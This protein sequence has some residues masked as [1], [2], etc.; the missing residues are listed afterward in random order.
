MLTCGVYGARSRVA[1]ILL[2]PKA[3]CVSVLQAELHSI[4]AE[5][6]V[7]TFAAVSA[8]EEQSAAL[9]RLMDQSRVDASKTQEM[10][11][12]VGVV[13]ALHA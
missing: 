10:L 8:A 7:A 2:P 11:E 1:C 9:K 6:R 5:I 12:Q 13:C 3:W 4:Q